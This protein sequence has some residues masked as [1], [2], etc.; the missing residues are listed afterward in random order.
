MAPSLPCKGFLFI[1]STLYLLDGLKTQNP[2]VN[3][4]FF[5]AGCFSAVNFN[6][7]ETMP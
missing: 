6:K 3:D 7:I 2:S 4:Y 5:D 1:T